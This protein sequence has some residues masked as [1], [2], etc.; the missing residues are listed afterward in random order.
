MLFM[1]LLVSS[2]PKHSGGVE[3]SYKKKQYFVCLS[4]A[5]GTNTT[6]M[7]GANPKEDG[8]LHN[9]VVV[10]LTRQLPPQAR[11]YLRI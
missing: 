5:I 4:T 2:H 7:L 8:P 3:I 11:E 6:I 9:V 10:D 1:L